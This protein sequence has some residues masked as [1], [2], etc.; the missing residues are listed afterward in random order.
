[1][2]AVPVAMRVAGFLGAW[3]FKIFGFAKIISAL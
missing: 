1:M 3:G 2:A